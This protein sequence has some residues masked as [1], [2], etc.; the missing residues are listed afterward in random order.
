ME[1]KPYIPADGMTIGMT[2]IIFVCE[3][4]CMEIHVGGI[5]TV[6][7]VLNNAEVENYL[8]EYADREI[9]A[10]SY[11]YELLGKS[12]EMRPATKEEMDIIIDDDF[13]NSDL[14]S[15]RLICVENDDDLKYPNGL[16]IIANTDGEHYAA[17]NKIQ[18]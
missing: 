5:C 3:V 12:L 18:F 4:E 17:M 11:S 13:P 10:Y 7:D 2:N 8:Q 9:K 16:T 15:D 6:K 1:K 14:Y